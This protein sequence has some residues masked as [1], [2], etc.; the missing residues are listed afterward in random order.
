MLGLGFL[1]PFQANCSQFNSSSIFQF[2]WTSIMVNC[3]WFA[4]DGSNYKIFGHRRRKCTDWSNKWWHWYF[5]GPFYRTIHYS[6]KNSFIIRMGTYKIFYFPGI[7]RPDTWR[8]W[9][10]YELLFCFE[11]K[12]PT[13]GNF[14]FTE[15]RKTFG[16]QVHFAWSPSLYW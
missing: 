9:I 8:L 15:K 16:S 2:E 13:N 7:D 4:F 11:W 1:N 14:G 6:G 10:W 3:W 5:Y 12:S